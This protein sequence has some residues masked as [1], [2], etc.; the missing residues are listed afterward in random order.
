M[1]LNFSQLKWSVVLVE[2]IFF[3]F[4]EVA[5][6]LGFLIRAHVWEWKDTFLIV[7]HTLVSFE[8]NI[9]VFIE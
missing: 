1:F 2:V 4:L 8:Q 5:H 9:L 7:F 3:F 6:F